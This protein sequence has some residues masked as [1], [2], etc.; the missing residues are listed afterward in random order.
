LV[1]S[2]ATEERG[3]V[4]RLA[5][6]LQALYQAEANAGAA[7]HQSFAAAASLS[8][9]ALGWRRL[10]VIAYKAGDVAGNFGIR[11]GESSGV[12]STLP[13]QSSEFHGRR[14]EVMGRPILYKPRNSS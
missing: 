11:R 5:G 14:K 7:V 6:G 1:A 8:S 10:A 13:G 2:Y 3:I 12:I 4:T 9:P